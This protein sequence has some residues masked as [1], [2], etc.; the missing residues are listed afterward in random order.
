MLSYMKC[1]HESISKIINFAVGKKKMARDLE[2]LNVLN[3]LVVSSGRRV[4]LTHLST[5]E[6]EAVST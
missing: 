4:M 3:G 5:W 2:S 6:E 1:N